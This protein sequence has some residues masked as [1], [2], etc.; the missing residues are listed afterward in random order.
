MKSWSPILSAIF[1]SQAPF[2]MIELE[3]KIIPFLQKHPASKHLVQKLSSFQLKQVFCG[4]GI[5][6]LQLISVLRWILEAA[7]GRTILECCWGY[8]LKVF[9]FFRNILKYFF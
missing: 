2:V 1:D 9:L 7:G 3:D 5:S 8:F 4:A 6:I